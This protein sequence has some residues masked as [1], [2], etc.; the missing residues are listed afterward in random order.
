MRWL[1]ES[2]SINNRQ[3]N[4]QSVTKRGTKEAGE[5]DYDPK[6]G[7]A[8]LQDNNRDFNKKI[9]AREQQLKEQKEE[10]LKLMRMIARQELKK[11]LK[12]WKKQKKWKNKTECAKVAQYSKC[13][14]VFFEG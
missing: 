7:T 1:Q 3:H 2:F 13:I 9:E 8:R 6:Q 12:D 11:C 5:R 10:M 14:Q 4:R